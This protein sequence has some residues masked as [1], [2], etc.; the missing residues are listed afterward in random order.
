MEKIKQKIKDWKYNLK[1]KFGFLKV[2][3]SPFKF[4][5]PKLYIGELALGVPYFYPRKWKK[6][7]KKD[8][9][10][11]ATEA[12]NNDK[13]VKR[14]FEDWCEHYKG[15]LKPID[16]KIGFD[17][18]GL[19]YKYKYD[20][21]RHEWN[22]IWSFVFFKWQIALSFIP[23][24]YD[25]YWESYVYYERHTDKNKTKRERIEQCRKEAPQIWISYHKGEEKETIDYY[26]LI[27]KKKYNGK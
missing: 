22:P 15:Y 11:S 5:L 27:L 24:N 13:L 4:F 10:E 7:T 25:H 12:I 1:D 6:F 18:V 2:Y 23:K 8:I 9:I 16:K 17:F 26:D 21:I 20:Q 14:T 19:G 3:F